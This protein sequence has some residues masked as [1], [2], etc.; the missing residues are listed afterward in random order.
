MPATHKEIVLAV[1]RRTYGDHGRKAAP[2][3]QTLLQQMIGRHKN[4]IRQS[5]RDL[6][7]EG[8]IVQV[9]APGFGSSA[10]LS[11]NKNY[12]TWGKWSVT[13][14]PMEE[15]QDMGEV[16]QGVGGEVQQGVGG[17]VQ[18]GVPIEDIETLEDLLTS[19]AREERE[20][21]S[22]LKSVPGYPLPFDYE[23]ELTFLREL[24]VDFP[25]VDLVEQLKKWKAYKLDVPLE[26]GRS[27]PHS[28]LR[29]WFSRIRTAD[30]KG[31]ER[32][33]VGAHSGRSEDGEW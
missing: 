14:T 1:I 26:P 27:R 2:I 15:P 31:G 13:Y 9:K 32:E 23:R 10:V 28:Q 33:R 12:E 21:L 7:A 20:C 18:Q 3:S 29:T 24:A 5:L 6:I 19:G 17:E 30:Q 22:V 25:A 16:Q 8:V 11:L 4:G